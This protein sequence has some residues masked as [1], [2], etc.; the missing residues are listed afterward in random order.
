MDQKVELLRTY[1]R[2]SLLV[3]SGLLEE[4]YGKKAAGKGLLS[5]VGLR[6]GAS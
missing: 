1:I 2:I 3:W 4:V 5:V 6:Y